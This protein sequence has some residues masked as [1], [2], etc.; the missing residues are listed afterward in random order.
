LFANSCIF[1][2][3]LGA[4]V[5]N[6]SEFYAENCTFYGNDASDYSN[7]G[8]LMGTSCGVATDTI[9]NCIFRE[10]TPQVF[11]GHDCPPGLGPFQVLGFPTLIVLV[12]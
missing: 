3:N 4:A 5:I 6:G 9:K 11:G 12:S 7:G 2:W 1:A 8:A 10:N